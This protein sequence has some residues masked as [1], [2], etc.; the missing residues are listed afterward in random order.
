MAL[1]NM[2][3]SCLVALVIVFIA[4]LLEI[5]SIRDDYSFIVNGPS[6]TS[7]LSFYEGWT[8]FDPA[9]LQNKF[10]RRAQINGLASFATLINAL[11]LFAVIIPILQVSWVLS[12]GGKKDLG[13]HAAICVLAMASSF[14]ILIVS[15]MMI[16]ARGA[17]KLIVERFEISD[18]GVTTNDDMTSMSDNT[19]WKVLGMIE[20][21]VIGMATWMNAFE[22]LCIFLILTILFFAIKS[23]NDSPDSSTTTF[24]SGGGARGEKRVGFGRKW[25]ILGLVVGILG[26]F[27]FLAEIM[28]LQSLVLYSRIS[29]FISILNSLVFV[30]I[31]LFVLG[32]QLPA[33]RADR[34]SVV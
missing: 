22:W 10:I 13:L 5:L 4:D 20:I 29:D 32:R 31:W 7:T 27:E 17:M 2:D 16:G 33:V 9:F 28:T 11:S 3:P 14:C 23:E 25:S 15:L 18:W 24:L 26:M 12:R 8:Q 19:G 34:K 21:V 1:F 30:P 6:P